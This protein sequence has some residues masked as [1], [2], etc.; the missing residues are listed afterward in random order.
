MRDDAFDVIQYLDVLIR[1]W[2]FVVAMPIVAM[3]AAMIVSI[4]TKPVYE[5]T[6]VIALSPA[7]LSV[8]TTNQA[9]PYYLMV[10]TPQHLPT[11]FSPTYYIDLLKGNE[12]VTQA[13]PQA[14]VAIVSDS[15][16]KSLIEITAQGGEPKQVQTTANTYAQ[17]GAARIQQ[18]LLPTDAD[19]AAA[20]KKLDAAEQALIKFSKDNDFD[21][22]DLSLL[23]YGNFLLG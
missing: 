23:L 16:D 21:T 17:V 4:A 9:P 10:D 19:A 1:R 14:A 13:A 15:G 12:V 22:Y 6:A 5:A 18:I 20:Q 3:I 8:P 7:T 11:T 2:R